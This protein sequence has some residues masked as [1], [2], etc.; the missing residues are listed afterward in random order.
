MKIRYNVCDNAL[1]QF[2][3]RNSIMVNTSLS[4][5][6]KTEKHRSSLYT[7]E[8]FSDC[9]LDDLCHGQ[10]WLLWLQKAILTPVC[11]DPELLTLARLVPDGTLY[12]TYFL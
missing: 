8:L 7:G 9:A 6:N 5:G 2:V 3:T 1:K 11:S 10:G 4:N 12:G